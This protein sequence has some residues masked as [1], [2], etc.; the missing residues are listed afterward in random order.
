MQI[1]EVQR[2]LK[3]LGFDPGPLDGDWGRQTMAAVRA[4]QEDRK[5]P[6]LKYPGTLGPTTIRYLNEE[7]INTSD[8]I[9]K[10]P[11][12]WDV[13]WLKEAL[14]YEGM[15]EV[16]GS[17]TNP[18]IAKWLDMLDAP[19]EG[20]ET[21]WCGTAMAAWI[22]T[23]LPNEVLPN[24]PWGSINWMKWGRQLNEPAIGAIMIFWRGSPTG[25]QGH[26]A[27]YVGERSDAYLVLGGNQDNMVNKTWISKGRLR[28]GGIR[29][30]KTYGLPMGWPCT[31]RLRWATPL[32]E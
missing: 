3:A 23:A 14:K 19:F 17:G 25:W 11:T 20:D 26:I 32:Q 6:G 29:W 31:S 4:Y 15:K 27:E 30:P 22:A 7:A 13:P 18:T 24:N 2:R 16:V 1:L 9:L 10:D 12:D 5:I 21:A 28:S 8:P